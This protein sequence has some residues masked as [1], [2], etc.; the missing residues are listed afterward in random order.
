MFFSSIIDWEGL[1]THDNYAAYK[2][3]FLLYNH[4]TISCYQNWKEKPSRGLP[5]SINQ[6]AYIKLFSYVP[7]TNDDS[8]VEA[9]QKNL[10]ACIRSLGKSGG[11]LRQQSTLTHDSNTW[12]HKL[13]CMKVV[14]P[15]SATINIPSGMF[16]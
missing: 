15:L 7:F 13:I 2:F 8:R 6:Q 16:L 4:Q 5:S 14:L 12:P 9:F 10:Q 11:F 3:L 1:T